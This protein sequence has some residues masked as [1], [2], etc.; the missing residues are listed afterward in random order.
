[1]SIILDNITY[2]YGAGTPFEKTALKDI[3]VTIEN[4]EFLGIIGHTGSGKSTFVQHLNGL[5][6]PTTGKVIVNGVDVS[7]KTDE[8]NGISIPRTSTV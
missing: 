7:E 4:G 1:M 8:A 5:L 3:S 6:H 2:T